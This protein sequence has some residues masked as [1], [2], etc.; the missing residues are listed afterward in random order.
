MK[1]N[2]I[3]YLILLPVLLVPS[4]AE[5]YLADIGDSQLTDYKVFCFDGIP[6]LIQVDYDRYN[7]H[8]RQFFDCDWNRLDISFHLTYFHNL[9]KTFYHPK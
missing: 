1:I 7:G 6:Q 3:R 5:E 8:K 4:C 9:Y 2:N